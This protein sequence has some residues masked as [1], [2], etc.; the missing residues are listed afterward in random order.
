MQA[1]RDRAEAD[2]QVQQS[3]EKLAER[4]EDLMKATRKC[5]RLEE[6]LADAQR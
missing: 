6:E 5:D 3:Q 1:E 2:R 4:V